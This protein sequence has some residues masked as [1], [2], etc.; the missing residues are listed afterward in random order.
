MNRAAYRTESSFESFKES[1]SIEYGASVLWALSLFA[2]DEEG[3]PSTKL[4]DLDKAKLEQPR[5]M[6]LKCLKNRFGNEY[7]LHFLYFSAVEKF[8]P[9]YEEDLL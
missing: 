7:K 9:C 2:T 4:E 6:V 8:L 5:P 3:K 1:G